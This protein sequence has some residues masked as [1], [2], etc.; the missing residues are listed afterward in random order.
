MC[1]SNACIKGK[2]EAGES[3]RRLGSVS[4]GYEVSQSLFTLRRDDRGGVLR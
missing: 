4:Q 3:F 2:G 1:G